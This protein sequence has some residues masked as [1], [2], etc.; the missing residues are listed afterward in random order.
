MIW[1][2]WGLCYHKCKPSILQRVR[3]SDVHIDEGWRVCIFAEL[4][5]P[6]CY[7]Y[8]PS[9]LEQL[10]ANWCLWS[11]EM[12]G[13]ALSNLY[14]NNKVRFGY[15]LTPIT[16]ANL[17]SL[18]QLCTNWCVDWWLGKV[19]IFDEKLLIW[20]FFEDK[21]GTLPSRMQIFCSSPYDERWKVCI[22][23]K[24]VFI[25]IGIWTGHDK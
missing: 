9:T 2:Y 11:W 12:D 19:C 17:P 15:N 22:S 3:T 7:K 21:F 16:N 5:G 4:L 8:K 24:K 1:D 18:Q 14:L 20:G 10:C 6:C 25:W 13:H 23:D